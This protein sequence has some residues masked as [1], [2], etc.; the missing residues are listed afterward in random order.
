[1]TWSVTWQTCRCHVA[2]S[3]LCGKGEPYTWGTSGPYS[4]EPRRTGGNCCRVSVLWTREQSRGHCM[5][6]HSEV[7]VW[8]QVW[9]S[10]L[11]LVRAGLGHPRICGRE[12]VQSMCRACAEPSPHS[13]TGIV[14]AAGGIEQAAELA[15]QGLVAE[16]EK[17]QQ[18]QLPR[19]EVADLYEQEDELLEAQQ[20]QDR[21]GKVD[22]TL[23]EELPVA[24]D[25][26]VRACL[27]CQDCR[28]CLLCYG[29]ALYSR[30]MTVIVIVI[31]ITVVVVVVVVI[32]CRGRFRTRHEVD[33]D[34]EC[35]NTGP[36]PRAT[37]LLA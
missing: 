3:T 24:M 2:S 9:D 5:M 26:Q 1:M 36:T 18:Q 20:V 32:M 31:V 6:S 29:M 30:C 34:C 14:A 28:E 21:P 23:L 17:E 7:L 11:A 4:R 13:L 37:H 35:S 33:Q 22:D 19:E 27:S 12:H 15:R 25:V 8:Q 16:K 10:T